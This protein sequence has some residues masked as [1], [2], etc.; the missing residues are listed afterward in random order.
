MTGADIFI[1]TYSKECGLYSYFSTVKQMGFIG[2]YWQLQSQISQIDEN[3]D[4]PFCDETLHL[5][6]PPPPPIKQFPCRDCQR[7]AQ[8]KLHHPLKVNM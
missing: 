3:G 5:L 1:A 7:I 4:N 2:K 6:C 8:V